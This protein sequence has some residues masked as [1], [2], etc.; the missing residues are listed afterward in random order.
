MAKY[1]GYKRPKDTKKTV[2]H[3]LTY[4]GHYKW[5]F[6]LIA[7]LVFI[8]AGAGIMGTFLIKPVVNNFIVPGNMK[9]LI[10]A[11][12]GMGV[13]YACGALSTLGYN[14][15]MVHTSQKVVSEIR[16][17]LFKHT[18]KLPLKYF[19]NNT[20]LSG[21]EK[22]FGAIVCGIK[23]GKFIER[24]KNGNITKKGTYKNGAGSDEQQ[25]C[26]GNP[27]LSYTF[28]NYNNDAGIKCK[29]DYYCCCF[30]YS[31]VHIYQIQW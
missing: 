11:V 8:S 12:C 24:D 22:M 26:D 19:D 1:V 14:R 28:W 5:A 27:E 29:A 2:K 25:L 9:G 16:M 3:I 10:I 6:L 17:D 30:S 23:D 18:Q 13:M 7:I 20:Q 21:I 15:L 4:L 31:Y